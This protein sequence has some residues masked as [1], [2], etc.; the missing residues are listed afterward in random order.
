MGMVTLGYRKGALNEVHPFSRRLD[1]V[2]HATVPLFW[3]GEVPSY[4][5]LRWKSKPLF[6]DA[7]LNP[8]VVN[9]LR[10]ILSSLISFARGTP[11]TRF[12]GTRVLGR[13]TVGLKHELRNFG[14]SIACVVSHGTL[15]SD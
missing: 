8:I 15:S 1:F 12:M 7:Q 14:V 6:N 4:T 2:P 3:D 10:L 11:K 9:A 13:E 5:Y